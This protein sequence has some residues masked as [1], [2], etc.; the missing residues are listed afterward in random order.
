MN[1]PV[2]SFLSLLLLPLLS[3]QSEKPSS[4]PPISEEP[5]LVSPESYTF[6]I[7]QANTFLYAEPGFNKKTVVDLKPQDA[8]MDLG[9]VSPFTTK[10]AI[11]GKTMD[12]PWLKV[13]TPQGAEG[14]IYGGFLKINPLVS[15]QEREVWEEKRLQALLGTE[16]YKLLTE[17]REMWKAADTDTGMLRSYQLGKRLQE[18]LG[19]YFEKKYAG[20]EKL[21]DLFG[22]T[23]YLPALIPEMS[24]GRGQYRFFLDFAAWREKAGQTKGVSDDHFFDLQL[25]LY[26]QDSIE[27]LYPAWMFPVSETEAHNLLGRGIQLESLK[28][29]SENLSRD[30]LFAGEYQAICRR[31]VEDITGAH[32]TFWEEKDQ[33]LNELDSLLNLP[34][35]ILSSHDRIALRTKRKLLEEHEQNAIPVNLKAGE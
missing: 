25:L 24:R 19:H 27:Y 17:Y 15:E 31:L 5:P 14:W 23:A 2:N 13:K 12:E 32:T 29:I 22:M 4:S 10:L 35:P 7:D 9:E 21:P 8:V 33:I 18:T 30:S 26:P 28:R 34:S 11:E 20:Q 16:V 1:F 3:C 6:F